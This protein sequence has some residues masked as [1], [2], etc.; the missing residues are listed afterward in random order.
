MEEKPQAP[1]TRQI[2]PSPAGRPH[3]PQPLP[4]RDADTSARQATGH[5]GSQRWEE[6][7]PEATNGCLLR[8][9]QVPP[10]AWSPEELMCLSLRTEPYLLHHV[11]SA[12]SSLPRHR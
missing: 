4:V 1:W 7:F 11:T 8:P 3:T 2:L 5:E 9:K 10:L 12:S 6:S